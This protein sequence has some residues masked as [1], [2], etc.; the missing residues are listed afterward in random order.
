[1]TI[2]FVTVM[3]LRFGGGQLILSIAAFVLAMLILS[4]MKLVEN[5]LRN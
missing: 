5:R 1:M 2:W 4:V 3:G